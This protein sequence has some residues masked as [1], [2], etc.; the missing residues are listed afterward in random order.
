MKK[1]IEKRT[2]TIKKTTP[3]EFESFKRLITEVYPSGVVS[4]VS[5]TF[6]LWEVLTNYLPRLKNI[7]EAR[8]G[9]I[10]IRPDSGNPVDIICGTNTSISDEYVFDSEQHLKDVFENTIYDCLDCGQ[11][12]YEDTISTIMKIGNKFYDVTVTA[13]IGSSKQDRGDKL[14]YI[15]GVETITILEHEITPE[16]KGAYELLWDTFGGHINDKGYKVLNTKVGLIY[17]DA[18]TLGRQK[19][20]LHRLEKK[21]FT[22][23]N[24]VLGIG[25]F[26]YNFN[27][28]DTFGFAMKAT[29]GE[30]LN[31][32]G[33]IE[34][35]PIYKDPIT[36]KGEKK[37][38]KGLLYVYNN[39]LDTHNDIL[40]FDNKDEICLKDQCTPKE[41]E[42]G[43]LIPIFKDGSIIKEYTLEEIRTRIK[44]QI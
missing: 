27:T 30:L 24:L 13:E 44:S 3:D 22:A 43:L 25:S 16:E 15:E 36:D 5:D 6:N 18:I 21:G 20:I 32:N 23:S 19:E 4:I 26:T 42:N 39:R 12:Y 34:Q 8:D 28:R 10:V 17:G 41:E 7:I 40:L 1:V 11:G 35:R 29:Y 33:N 38:A 2:R 31:T 9:R 14:Y 37:S